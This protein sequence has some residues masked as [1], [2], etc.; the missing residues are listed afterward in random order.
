MKI[1][2]RDQSISLSER[3]KTRRE[4]AQKESG[5]PAGAAA[6]AE[7]DGVAFAAGII[8]S[9]DNGRLPAGC[10]PAT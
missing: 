3:S 6:T 4:A 7:V 2:R 5:L 9:P 8:A 10:H 1:V